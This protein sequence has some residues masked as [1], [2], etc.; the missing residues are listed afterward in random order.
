MR[1]NW[2]EGRYLAQEMT[3]ADSLSGAKSR[4]VPIVREG[5]LT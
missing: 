1:A 3:N 2:L 5:T 4:N